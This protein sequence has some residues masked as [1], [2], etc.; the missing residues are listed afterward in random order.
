[1]ARLTRRE[2]KRDELVTTLTKL[3]LAVEKHAKSILVAVIAIVVLAGA[4]TA[5]LVYSRS[6]DRAAQQ[7]LGGV[8]KTAMAPVS[9]ALLSGS[10]TY[11]T[12]EAKYG[13][14]IRLSDELL[15]TYPSSP[16]ARWTHYW[17]GLALKELGKTAE[18][19][20]TLASL[21]EDTERDFVYWS[22]QF[23]KARIHEASGDLEAAGQIYRELADTAPEQFP[24]EMALM[25]YARLLDRQGKRSE[26][27]EVYQR[28]STDYPDS[29]F[30]R[31]AAINMRKSA[32]PSF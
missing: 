18:A 6:R 16:S 24:V 10:G 3:S 30:A 15:E 28:V 13:E 32:E 1:V 20:E 23:L 14:V 7:A 4:V 8:Y 21:D 5:G 2:M 17:K 26:A 19:V 11:P 31:T 9:D 29:P 12:A 25:N 27:V 22:V